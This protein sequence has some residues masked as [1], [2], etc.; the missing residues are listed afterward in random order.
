MK[1]FEKYNNWLL[2]LVFVIIVI[3]VYKTFDNFYKIV[4]IGKLI[5]NSLSPFLFGFV[6]AYVLNM[7]CKKI[8]A[9]CRKS[10]YRFINNKSKAISIVSVYLLLVLVVYVVVSAVAPALYR[11]FIDLYN[12]IPSY[13][14]QFLGAVE[15]WQ[16]MYGIELFDINEANIIK[17]FNS[18]FSEFNIAE[19][20]KYA[21]GVID[22]TSG[23]INIFIGII[24]SVYMLI[25]KEKIKASLRRVLHLVFKAEKSK[26]L[27]DNNSFDFE[28]ALC[29]YPWCDDWYAQSYPVFRRNFCGG[30]VDNHYIDYR[31]MGESFVDGDCF[32][33]ASTGGRKLHRTEDYGTNA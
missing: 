4:E 10:K 8:D 16:K 17:A 25:D 1:K 33:C 32:D 13:I 14:D 26:K 31:R 19:F 27:I 3:A 20:S 21:K 6:I 22:I 5:F 18:F 28:C 11:N 2:A 29:Y 24:I 15:G 23:V 30:V 9:L 12:N 7:P